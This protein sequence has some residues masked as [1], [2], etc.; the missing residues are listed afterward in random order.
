MHKNF[1]TVTFNKIVPEIKKN[2]LYNL[3]YLS[4]GKSIKELK[5]SKGSFK[6]AIVVGAGPSLRRNNQIKV[7]K[8]YIQLLCII[9]NGKKTSI[10]RW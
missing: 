5:K 4:K 2:V 8:K 9:N 3:K 6:N 1:A 7:L 10:I